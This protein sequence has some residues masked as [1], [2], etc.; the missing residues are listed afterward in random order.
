MSVGQLQW[1]AMAT[2]LEMSLARETELLECDQKQREE[3]PTPSHVSSELRHVLLR[4]RNSVTHIGRGNP[5]LSQLLALGGRARCGCRGAAYW[6]V[7]RDR[8][9]KTSSSIKL[10]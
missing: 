5:A 1:P 9:L 8:R 7:P 3:L 2:A 10:T 4:D 6:Q